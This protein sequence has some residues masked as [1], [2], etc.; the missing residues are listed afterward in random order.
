MAKIELVG[1]IVNEFKLT[2]DT[3]N[4]K[5][6]FKVIPDVNF[7]H[8][9]FVQQ[10]LLTYPTLPSNVTNTVNAL[11]NICNSNSQLISQMPIWFCSV[12]STTINPFNNSIPFTQYNYYNRFDKNN[13]DLNSCYLTN[14]SI[15]STDVAQRLEKD[16]RVDVLLFNI[17][18]N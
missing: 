14:T 6:Y 12:P 10:T 9:A 2:I 18:E 15:Y 3:L 16:L 4:Q 13:I 7:T 17:Y 1:N 11:I 8:F 5:Q